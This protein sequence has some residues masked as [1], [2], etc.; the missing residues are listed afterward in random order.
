MLL[1]AIVEDSDDAIISKTLEGVVTSW[2]RAAERLFGYAAAEIQGRHIFVLAAPGHEA[3]MPAI[4]ERIRRG[5]RV[6]HFETAWRR[7][8]GSLVDVSLTVSPIRD[9]SGAIIGASKIARDITERQ[10]QERELQRREAEYRAIFEAGEAAKAEVE[11]LTGRLLRVNRAYCELLGY[12]E[13]ELLGMT[14][15]D[16][17]NPDDREHNEASYNRLPSGEI[18]KFQY[19][20]RYVRKDGR[21]VWGLVSAVVLRDADGQPLRTVAVVQD[22]SERKRAE[23][24][25][26]RSEELRRLALQAGELG[27]WDLDAT[28]GILAC[29]DRFRELLGFVP[30]EEVTNEAC[31]A[32]VHPDDVPAVQAAITHARDP[33]SGGDYEA[34]FRIVVPGRTERWLLSRARV[35]FDGE[36]RGA[37]GSPLR[38]RGHRS[39]AAQAGRDHG[40]ATGPAAR[41]LAGGNPRL[42][43]GRRHRVLECGGRGSLRPSARGSAGAGEPRAAQDEASD[44]HCLVRGVAGTGGSLGRRAGPLRPG[45]PTGRGGEPSGGLAR[46]RRPAPG[47]RDQSRHHRAQAGRGAAALDSGDRAGGDHHHR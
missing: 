14:A 7:K 47:A 33:V 43:A 12:A 26:Q 46:A 42:G 20:K 31:W 39:H 41:P 8:D 45:R 10:R 38:R 2:N 25:L 40:P 15:W 5:E 27:L 36:G 1:A 13:E 35:Y 9:R 28:T 16:V 44:G 19:E 37:A 29:D 17:T 30:G 22:V 21:T 34:E 11:P 6:D 3:E 24:G 18:D 32:R 4:L 23:E